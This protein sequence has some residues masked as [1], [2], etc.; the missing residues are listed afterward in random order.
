MIVY[1]SCS[2]LF[3]D[4]RCD[5]YVVL[6]RRFCGRGYCFPVADFS[7]HPFGNVVAATAA[8][9]DLSSRG[10]VCVCDSG[11]CGRSGTV[12]AAALAY[13]NRGLSFAQL[14]KLLR[15]EHG[16]FKECPEKVEQREAVKIM[17]SA[18]HNFSLDGFRLLARTS[19]VYLGEPGPREEAGSFAVGVT[20]FAKK[21]KFLPVRVIG[22]RVPYG[23]EARIALERRELERVGG[24]ASAA[25]LEEYEESA[26]EGRVVRL[27][28]LSPE[29][30]APHALSFAALE[31]AAFRTLDPER[32]L[33]L[34]TRT[35]LGAARSKR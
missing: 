24:E 22:K 10:S 13:L 3:H 9:V 8:T 20:K 16:L 31:G 29:E 5:S 21:L 30:V 35:L 17:W 27:E 34:L 15:N 33:V 1:G 26:G 12:A 11:G 14:K 2:N 28:D 32:A 18:F 4:D 6:D 7:V 25:V 23:K 19:Y